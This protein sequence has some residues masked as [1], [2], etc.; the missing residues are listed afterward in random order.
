METWLSGRK[1]LTANEA[2][3]KGSRGFESL[4]LRKNKKAPLCGVFL[5]SAWRDEKG[6][7]ASA[8]SR[9]RGN[10]Q[11]KIIR[12]RIPAYTTSRAGVRPSKKSI[13]FSAAATDMDSRVFSVADPICGVRIIF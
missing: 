4:R 1:Y 9:G 6:A 8:P 13:M 5:F 3:L 11:Q 12:D 7:G 2:G 10:F